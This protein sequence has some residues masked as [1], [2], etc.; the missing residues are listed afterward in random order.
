MSLE[1]APFQVNHPFPSF[2]ILFHPFLSF[3]ILFLF[4]ENMQ[5]DD[6]FT[7]ISCNI[8]IISSILIPVLHAEPHEPSE[9]VLQEVLTMEGDDPWRKSEPVD[10]NTP[11]DIQYPMDPTGTK[12]DS[13]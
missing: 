13:R 5:K 11:M 7:V 2:S 12:E 4:M 8:I 3:S 1:M 6:L 10:H 9:A